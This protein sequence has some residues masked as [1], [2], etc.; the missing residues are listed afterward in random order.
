[1]EDVSSDGRRLLNTEESK[2]LWAKLGERW[3]VRGVGW[4]WYPISD[5]PAPAGSIVVHT[6]LWDSRD[7]DT[8]LRQALA[9]RG[10]R[11]CYELREGSPEYELDSAIA[12]CDYDGRELF[13]TSDFE[14]L[15]Y[16]SHECSITL[17][18][19][20]AEFFVRAW[21]DVAGLQY[22]G[23]YHTNDLRG[24]ANPEEIDPQ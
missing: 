4:G 11:R 20:I 18:G 3:G 16:A 15:L 14:W 1:M 2:Q 9:E 10:V 5:D 22:R 7:G 19:W 12:P 24:T 8:L 13:L 17:A 23:P 21:P 6:E